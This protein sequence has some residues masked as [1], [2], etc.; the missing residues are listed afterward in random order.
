[1]SAIGRGHRRLPGVCLALVV[2]CKAP[3]P[4]ITLAPGASDVSTRN[5]PQAVS[6]SASPRPPLSATTEASIDVALARV[7]ARRQLAAK[8]HVS[9]RRVDRHKLVDHARSKLDGD[10]P[11]C[12]VNGYETL[13]FGLGVVPPSFS[14]ERAMTTLLGQ[15]LAGVYDPD[16][17][18]LLVAIDLDPGEADRTIDHELV[19]ALQDQ[20]FRLDGRLN[21]GFDRTDQ[22]GALQTLAEGDATC[23][24]MDPPCSEPPRIEALSCDSPAA[25]TPASERLPCL[26]VR[27][28][29]APY[30]DGVRAVRLLLK[31][32][33][34]EAVN[35]VWAAPPATTH[36]LLHLDSP[37]RSTPKSP[38]NVPAAPAQV[39]GDPVYRDVLGEQTLRIVLEEWAPGEE[40]ADIASG[41]EGDRVAVF[42]TDDRSA[43]AWHLRFDS[44]SR[45][46][47]AAAVLRH[48][49]LRSPTPPAR[50]GLMD[51]GRTPDMS[52]SSPTVRCRRHADRGPV[53]VVTHGRDIAVTVGPFRRNRLNA[54]ADGT[55]AA[56]VAWAECVA[57]QK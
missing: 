43:V 41:W 16:L 39:F 1:M 55:C 13:L 33:G 44:T 11:S 38:P 5:T 37:D 54:S 53:A 24:T 15:T 31:R 40:A 34:W 8:G 26:L 51:A 57:R 6:G 28:L 56:T 42:R 18:T 22:Q 30:V 2:A 12:V 29:V 35:A 19:H 17:D 49:L 50:T 14:F 4:S 25:G 27:S 36:Q 23:A 32:G 46:S 20:H 21:L 9:T 48:G 52:G 47:R 10:E 45:T 3:S 7:S